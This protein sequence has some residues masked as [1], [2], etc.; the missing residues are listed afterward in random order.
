MYFGQTRTCRK[1]EIVREDI[2][3][4]VKS[5]TTDDYEQALRIYEKCKHF[6]K[7]HEI[8]LIVSLYGN[9]MLY[10]SDTVNPTRIIKG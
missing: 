4:N 5:V 8:T 7:Q 9:G 2:K 1:Y 10:E 6:A 3:G